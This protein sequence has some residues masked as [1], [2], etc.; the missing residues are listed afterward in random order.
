MTTPRTTQH[1][2]TWHVA[3]LAWIADQ[4]RPRFS[5]HDLDDRMLADIGLT[6]AEISSVEAEC[7]GR[8]AP[9]RLRVGVLAQ[10]LRG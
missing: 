3:V 8:A 5:L 10:A 9:T 7:T 6:R 2:N 4:L 1:R